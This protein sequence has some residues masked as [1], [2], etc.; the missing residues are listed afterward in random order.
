MDQWHTSV[1]T[2]VVSLNKLI[3][4]IPFHFGNSYKIAG[5]C[6]IVQKNFDFVVQEI[7]KK[8]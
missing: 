3:K 4:L 1:K 5:Y 2:Q 8:I 6:K 7:V